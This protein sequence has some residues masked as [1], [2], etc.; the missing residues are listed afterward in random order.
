MFNGSENLKDNTIGNQQE[1][2]SEW[3][4]GIIEN[5]RMTP[6][7]WSYIDE[8]DIN[9]VQAILESLGAD[10]HIC[11]SWLNENQVWRL[12]VTMPRFLD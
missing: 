12:E 4:A 6:R 7:T 11:L 2:V 1:T 5:F 8:A 3:L 9:K 10:Y